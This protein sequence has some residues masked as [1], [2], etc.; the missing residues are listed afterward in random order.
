MS[1]RH[2]ALV[3]S[4]E[5]LRGVWSGASTSLPPVASPASNAYDGEYAGEQALVASD[6]PCASVVKAVLSVRDGQVHY[7][8][9]VIGSLDGSLEPG[10]GGMIRL[11]RGRWYLA[12]RIGEDG[13]TGSISGGACDYVYRLHRATAAILAG[14]TSPDIDHSETALLDEPVVT[15]PTVP[16]HAGPA[17]QSRPKPGATAA[18]LSRLRHSPAP[19]VRTAAGAASPSQNVS[20]ASASAGTG[21]TPSISGGPATPSVVSASTQSVA[22]S[23]DAEGASTPVVSQ[24]PE[25]TGPNFELPASNPAGAAPSSPVASSSPT[26]VSLSGPETATRA[27]DPDLSALRLEGAQTLALGRASPERDRRA[28]AALAAAVPIL[29]ELANR[30]DTMVQGVAQYD[31]GYCYEHGVGVATDKLRAYVYYIRASVAP[32]SPPAEDSRS[33]NPDVTQAAIKAALELQAALT[34][35][36]YNIAVAMLQQG[37][38]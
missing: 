26:P 17:S 36:D 2:A 8:D 16:Q 13:I 6:G 35:S 33:A 32:A 3:H 23:P 37:S 14:P 24:T 18:V 34:P 38:P 22:P 1:A 19:S 29:Q 31:L 21:S 12:G 20:E 28:A 7:R 9:A 11:E 4:Q 27:V 25:T 5:I 10:T 15:A 30:P